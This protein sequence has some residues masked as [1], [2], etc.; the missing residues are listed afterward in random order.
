MT[1]L[2]LPSDLFS[3]VTTAAPGSRAPAWKVLLD[4]PRYG[5]THIDYAADTPGQRNIWAVRLDEAVLR[6]DKPV[7][8]IASGESCLAAA[9]WA[10][11]SPADYV[12]KVAGALLFAPRAGA[13]P[14]LGQRIAGRRA[15]RRRHRLET[16]PG[17]ADA[18]NCPRR[19]TRDA[20]GAGA[21]HRRLAKWCSRFRP[22]FVVPDLEPTP[23]TKKARRSPG[24]TSL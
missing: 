21:R 18:P 19:R 2:A 13:C 12:A 6:A 9:W 17:R 4:W 10:R 8:L 22:Y 24:P 7:L 16:R 5:D 23:N 11:L 1:S 15:G 14:G 3:V 20:R